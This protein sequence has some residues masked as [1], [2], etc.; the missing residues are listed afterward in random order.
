M[1]FLVLLLPQMTPI[2]MVLI[3]M[4]IHHLFLYWFFILGGGNRSPCSAADGSTK[5]SLA[6]HALGQ[7]RG[8][9]TGNHHAKRQ[10]PHPLHH[11][12]G[13]IKKIIRNRS[14]Q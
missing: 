11:K 6:I 1:A 5:Y 14:P 7:C 2:I 8:R 10:N 4:E 12:S 3:F 13:L 9:N